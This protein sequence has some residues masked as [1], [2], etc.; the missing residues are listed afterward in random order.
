MSSATDEVIATSLATN[1]DLR[2]SAYINAIRK[3]DEYYSVA[4]IR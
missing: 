1:V 3:L 2:T 4:G